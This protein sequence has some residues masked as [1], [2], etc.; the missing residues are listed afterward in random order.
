M[1]L[2]IQKNASTDSH[3]GSNKSDPSIKTIGT[4]SG[5]DYFYLCTAKCSV[6]VYIR[7]FFFK[8][9]RN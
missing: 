1:D 2:K 5:Y 6:H 3:C 9:Y 4:A 8:M 7:V